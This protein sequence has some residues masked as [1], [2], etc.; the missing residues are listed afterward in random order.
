VPHLILKKGN[1]NKMGRLRKVLSGRTVDVHYVGTLD[2]GTKFDSSRDRDEA[3]SFEVGAGEMIAGFDT[4]VVGMK[5][6]EVKNIKLSPGEAY[7]ELN[8]DLVQTVPQAAFPPDFQFGIG[9]MVQ[10]K[11]AEGR[12]FMAVIHSLS[13]EGVTLDLNH[14]MAGK[15]LNFEIEIMNVT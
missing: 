12:P 9:N 6:G 8:P 10:G 3:V 13:E 14:P 5:I 2:D 4:A 15:N 11:D 1:I 7:G